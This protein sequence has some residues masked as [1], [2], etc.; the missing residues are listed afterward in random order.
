MVDSHAVGAGG[1]SGMGPRMGSTARAAECVS[2]AQQGRLVSVGQ[3][4]WA[5]ASMGLES[6]PGAS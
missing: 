5:E 3:P 6:S 1:A 4:S 2:T